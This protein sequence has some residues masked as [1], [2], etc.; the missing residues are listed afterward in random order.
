MKPT[1]ILLLGLALSA[2]SCVSTSLSLSQ[3]AQ[4][5]V[6]KA[7]KKSGVVAYGR[8]ATYY[9]RDAD[10]VF[11]E[12]QLE[13]ED[14]F[15]RNGDGIA[16]LIQGRGQIST[17]LR[18]DED[19]DGVLDHTITSVQGY[20]HQWMFP[21]TISTP[22]PNIFKQDRITRTSTCELSEPKFLFWESLLNLTHPKK[23]SR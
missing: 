7:G 2:P 16:D 19:F 1:L 17:V 6:K 23:P 18:W 9:D 20:V 22:A 12:A 11:E 10:G 5:A 4:A 14:Y 15:D 13:T 3:Q 21:G 8:R